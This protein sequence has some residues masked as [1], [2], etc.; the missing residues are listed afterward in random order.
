MLKQCSYTI[1]LISPKETY[2]L[3]IIERTFVAVLLIM[4][5]VPITTKIVS[6]NPTHVEV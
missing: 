6:S 1:P 5:S 2:D 3:K 4:Q